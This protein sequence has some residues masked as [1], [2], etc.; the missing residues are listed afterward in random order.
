MDWNLL[1]DSLFSLGASACSAL[2]VYGGWLC[3]LAPSGETLKD[4]SKADC[5][6]AE[7]LRSSSAKFSSGAAL[8]LLVAVIALGISGLFHTLA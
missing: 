5:P 7:R 2:L 3:Y 8:P 4:L 1:M 6:R